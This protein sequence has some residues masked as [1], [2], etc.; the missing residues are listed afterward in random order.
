MYTP[1][2][3]THGLLLFNPLTRLPWLRSSA[4]VVFSSVPHQCTTCMQLTQINPKI[5]SV[6][7]VVVERRQPSFP[8][9]GIG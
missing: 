6:Q 8:P 7:S 4:Y 9:E 3:P 2:H 1:N 5:Q